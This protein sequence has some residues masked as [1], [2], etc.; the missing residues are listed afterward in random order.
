MPVEDPVEW[1]VLGDSFIYDEQKVPSLVGLYIAVPWR[2][3]PG[4]LYSIFLL[5]LCTFSLPT[6]LVD[7]N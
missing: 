4:D 6:L 2:V 1:V 3:V 7:R 5:R